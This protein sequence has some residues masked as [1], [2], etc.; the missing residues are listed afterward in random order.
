MHNILR[1]CALIIFLTSPP[2]DL[3]YIYIVY[4]LNAQIFLKT[5]QISWKCATLECKPPLAKHASLKT[6]FSLI[7][8]PSSLFIAVVKF[9]C[10]ILACWMVVRKHTSTHRQTDT[11]T[12]TQTQTQ[13]HTH[14][15]SCFLYSDPF[16]FRHFAAFNPPFFWA[17]AEAAPCSVC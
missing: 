14:I 13:T 3:H 6:S 5:D 2:H 17:P 16:Y 7:P 10:L 12:Q 9:Y 8:S 1:F 15:P 11:Q 4:M